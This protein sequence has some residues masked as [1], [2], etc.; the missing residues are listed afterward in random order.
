MKRGGQVQFDYAWEDPDSDYEGMSLQVEATI[1]DYHP[2]VMYLANGDPGHPEEG[3]TVDDMTVTSP[4]GTELS[5]IPAA[6]C[7]VLMEQAMEEHLEGS[8]YG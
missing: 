4:D 3:G 2:A 7:K 5:P 1:S 8:C 6:L